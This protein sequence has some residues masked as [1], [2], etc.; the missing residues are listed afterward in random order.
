M[1]HTEELC[2]LAWH[3]DDAAGRKQI[4][5]HQSDKAEKCHNVLSEAVSS[6]SNF[7]YAICNFFKQEEMISGGTCLEPFPFLLCET[8]CLKLLA[9]W[10][11]PFWSMDGS[12]YPTSASSA[13]PRAEIHHRHWIVLCTQAI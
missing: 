6:H 12:C 4:A 8:A 2:V 11:A 7:L 3:L 1:G 10:S 13:T 9:K 5:N